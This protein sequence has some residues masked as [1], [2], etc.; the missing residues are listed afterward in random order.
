MVLD[1]CLKDSGTGMSGIGVWSLADLIAGGE[2]R[3]SDCIAGSVPGNRSCVEHVCQN[4]NTSGMKLNPTAL[5]CCKISFIFRSVV[6]RA[7]TVPTDSCVFCSTRLRWHPAVMLVLV[8]QRRI[9]QQLLINLQK[10]IPIR[11]SRKKCAHQ[12]CS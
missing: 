7:A 5:G 4:G 12:N 10:E 3:K 8:C 11:R 9:S 2:G 1:W 6:L